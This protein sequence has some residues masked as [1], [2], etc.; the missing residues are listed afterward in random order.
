V[1]PREAVVPKTQC[2]VLVEKGLGNQESEG[3]REGERERLWG[4]LRQS[5]GRVEGA[6]VKS[7]RESIL[8]R[9]H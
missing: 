2:P 5:P 8:C 9:D 1:W 6:E 3:E 7:F 4:A